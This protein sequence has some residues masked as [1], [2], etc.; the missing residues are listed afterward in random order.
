MLLGST[1]IGGREGSMTGEG[2]AELQCKPNEDL[3]QPHVELWNWNDPLELPRVGTRRPGL[4]ISASTS[5]WMLAALEKS[6]TFGRMALLSWENS[7]QLCHIW[8]E[9]AGKS[10]KMD[11]GS[12]AQY[13]QQRLYPKIS[14]SCLPRVVFCFVFLILYW[15]LLYFP[16][17]K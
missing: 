7:Q 12:G 2:E 15:S 8:E 10:Q 16:N 14:T 13:L 1:C 5:H 6:M 17:K 4:H 11:L 3:S 9:E